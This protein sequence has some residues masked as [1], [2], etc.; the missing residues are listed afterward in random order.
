MTGKTKQQDSNIFEVFEGDGEDVKPEQKLEEGPLKSKS[1]GQAP[2]KN[3]ETKG[4]I[5]AAQN[6]ITEQNKQWFGFG[7]SKRR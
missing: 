6:A 3:D 4:Y 5:N 2:I 1:I 7:V